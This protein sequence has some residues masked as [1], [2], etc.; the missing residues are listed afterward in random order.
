MSHLPLSQT[1]GKNTRKLNLKQAANADSLAQ[2]N[3]TRL[4]HLILDKPCK[5]FILSYPK[6][7]DFYKLESYG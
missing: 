1:A 4:A 7:I 5:M 3:K 6:F 2:Y